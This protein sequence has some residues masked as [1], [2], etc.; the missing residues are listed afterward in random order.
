[1]VICDILHIYKFL[2]SNEK[3]ERLELHI[4]FQKQNFKVN[5]CEDTRNWNCFGC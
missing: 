3:L 2:N 4:W 1:M 5:M